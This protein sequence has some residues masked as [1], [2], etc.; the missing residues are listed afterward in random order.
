MSIKK[1]PDVI[2]AVI[3]AFEKG[4]LIPSFHAEKQ[5]QARYIQMSDIE[6]MIYRAHIEDHKDSP[7]NDGK[8]WKYSL[9][10]LNDKGDKDIRI[11]VVFNGP[12]T[13]VVTAIDMNKKET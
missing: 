9:R 13:V 6:E 10:G 11:I 4:R 2:H 3:K 5:M 12:D 7:R 1:R 8:D